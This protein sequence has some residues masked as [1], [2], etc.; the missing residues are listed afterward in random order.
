M[1]INFN[2]II[3]F[4]NYC[5]EDN[6]FK[7]NITNKEKF[8]ILDLNEKDS[9]FGININKLKINNE[10]ILA[11]I[12]DLNKNIINKSMD[13]HSIYLEIF[14]VKNSFLSIDIGNYEL[15]DLTFNFFNFKT[16]LILLTEIKYKED[17]LFSAQALFENENINDFNIKKYLTYSSIKGSNLI[18]FEFD[19]INNENIYID[20]IINKN[21]YEELEFHIDFEE[22]ND[23]NK[24]IKFFENILIE[25]LSEIL[26]IQKFNIS[27]EKLNK[28]LILNIN[29]FKLMEIRLIN[30]YEIMFIAKLLF[31]NILFVKNEE[32]F[33]LLDK[34]NSLLFL[35]K[36]E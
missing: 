1:I 17:I 16:G 3:Y 28:K 9:L 19:L 36:S 35:E 21:Q 34:D 2:E 32:K 18:N 15:S 22:T 13:N 8:D 4:N 23:L 33:I 10:Y 14:S 29:L 20:L 26:N 30:I 25:N 12:N 7:R 31:K 6:L 24:N 5:I 11:I 27:I